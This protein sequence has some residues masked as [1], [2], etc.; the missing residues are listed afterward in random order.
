M[1]DDVGFGDL[2]EGRA[3]RRDEMGRQLGDETHRIRQNGGPAGGQLEAPHGRV[4]G[5]EQHVSGTDRCA[6][7]SVEQ[8]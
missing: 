4:E 8:R 3:K 2:F 5:R 1:D 7:Q 6:G